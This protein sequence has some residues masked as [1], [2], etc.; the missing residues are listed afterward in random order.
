MLRNDPTY[1]SCVW[2]SPL[3]VNTLAAIL[4]ILRTKHPA[5]FVV[6]SPCADILLEDLEKALNR[7]Y[8]KEE[9]HGAGNTFRGG[10]EEDH[11]HLHPI[12]FN[13]S[14]GYDD[15]EV[16]KNVLNH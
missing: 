12:R 7:L 15:T 4:H 8:Q 11:V 14:R 1:L 10:G 9:Q 6:D 16:K 2:C 3:F 13:V 5:V